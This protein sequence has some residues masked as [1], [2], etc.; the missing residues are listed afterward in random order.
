MTINDLYEILLSN[1]PSIQI[2]NN[3]KELFK[4]IP[5]LEKCKGFNQ[6]NDWHI[7]D[8]YEHILH[9][10]DYVDND[11][12]L[13]LAALFHDI[14]KPLV[15][16]EDINGVGHFYGHWTK[17]QDIFDLF[18]LTH[19]IDDNISFMVSNLILF[20]DKNIGKLNDYDLNGLYKLFG[21]NGIELLFKLKDADLLAQNSKYHYLLNDY[22]EQK[23]KILLKY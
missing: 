23:K 22:E 18:A 4:L 16:K 6:N 10:V 13:R 21:Y 5:E 20:H 7:Y 2:K 17:S 8:V 1:N 15:Y 3:E 14:G 9:V 11:I 12:I 19:G